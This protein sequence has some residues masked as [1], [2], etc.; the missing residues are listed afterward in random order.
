MFE[1]QAAQARNGEQN[2]IVAAFFQLAEAGVHVA[3]N[4]L[5]D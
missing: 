4:R 2:G 3:T 1:A 5:D